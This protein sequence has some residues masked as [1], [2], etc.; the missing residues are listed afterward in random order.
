MQ[1]PQYYMKVAEFIRVPAD[2][3]LSYSELYH[4]YT[5]DEYECIE[6]DYINFGRTKEEVLK[7]VNTLYRREISYVPVDVIYKPC[8]AA[9][10]TI[11]L[12]QRERDCNSLTT[13][14]CPPSLYDDKYNF[15]THFQ[16]VGGQYIIYDRDM[17][18]DYYLDDNSLQDVC[19]DD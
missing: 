9:G 12:P 3:S 8:P 18:V 5:G 2:T 11:S 19:W 13:G 16:F 14:G 6:E 7:F 4:C 15:V 17:S 1:R 10:S